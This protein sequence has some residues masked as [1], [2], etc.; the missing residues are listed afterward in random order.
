MAL[1]IQG[2]KERQFIDKSGE[3]QGKPFSADLYKARWP[4]DQGLWD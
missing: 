2:R 1:C 3:G 4:G